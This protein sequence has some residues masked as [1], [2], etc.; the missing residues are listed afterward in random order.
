MCL[1]NIY[2]HHTVDKKNE[3]ANMSFFWSDIKS[4]FWTMAVPHYALIKLVHEKQRY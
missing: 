1:H 2:N 3:L 4:Q